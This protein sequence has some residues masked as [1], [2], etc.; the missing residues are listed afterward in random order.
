M[1]PLR[2]PNRVACSLLGLALAAGLAQAQDSKPAAADWAKKLTFTSADGRFTLS[3]GNRV[4]VRYD[5]VDFTPDPAAP[6][7]QSATADSSTF[8]IRRARTTFEGTAFGDVAYKLQLDW[9]TNPSLL[10]AEIRYTKYPMFQPWLGRGKAFFGRQQLTSSGRLQFIDRSIVDSALFPGRQNGVAVLGELPSRV[11]EYQVGLYNGNG[12][13]NNVLNDDDEFM[14]TQRVVYH[15]FGVMSLEEGGTSYPERFTMSIGVAAL[16]NTTRSVPTTTFDDVDVDRL[17]AELAMAWK[18][19]S[20][21]GEYVSEDTA[22]KRTTLATTTSPVAVARRP[23]GER[24]GFYG[25]V[26]YL[27]PN[28]KLEL[29]LRH[30]RVDTDTAALGAIARTATRQ[31]EDRVAVSWYVAKHDFKVQ[32]D[33]GTVELDNAL[34]GRTAREQDEIRAQLQISF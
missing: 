6:P 7:G 18:G 8:R 30:A 29:A 11:L 34:T 16:Q 21:V 14:T 3:L 17:G 26:G 4:Q 24:D 15:P 20:A 2:T 12:I 9:L 22:T 31:T 1:K 27:L 10:D 33:Y 32:L 5:N 13:A 28:R 23:D 19:F 25:Q